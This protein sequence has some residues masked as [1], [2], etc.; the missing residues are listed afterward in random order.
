MG[1][2][3]RYTVT[4][5]GQDYTVVSDA[6]ERDVQHMREDVD[7]IVSQ[8]LHS[9]PDTTREKAAILA[10]LKLAERVHSLESET[11]ACR[12]HAERITA[13]LQECV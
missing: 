10:A 2:V 3:H 11:D 7:R 9:K 6:S 12:T 8:I 13:A 4:I 1:N 5:G